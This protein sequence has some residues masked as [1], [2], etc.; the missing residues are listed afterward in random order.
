MKP[1]P[2]IFATPYLL[3]L[4]AW[5][6]CFIA[7]RK[8]NVEISRH[9]PNASLHLK[10]APFVMLLSMAGTLAYGYIA[11]TATA[12]IQTVL[13]IGTF[14]SLAH[15]YLIFCVLFYGVWV[16]AAVLTPGGRSLNEA[17]RYGF[18]R[19]AE[20]RTALM[21]AVGLSAFLLALKVYLLARMLIVVRTGF[22]AN[23]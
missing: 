6:Y 11:R 12:T 5:G 22:P 14:S 19:A 7:L 13:A 23:L 1:A 3:A 16:L 2:F 9:N 15:L 4:A 8:A 21:V 17:V 18:V 10:L 20:K